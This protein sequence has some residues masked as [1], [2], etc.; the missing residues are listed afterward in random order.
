MDGTDKTTQQCAEER[1]SC[2]SD[3]SS[4]NC[5]SEHLPYEAGTC[6]AEG[7]ADGHLALPDGSARHENVCDVCTGEQ[8]NERAEDQEQ[9]R[10]HNERIVGV[11]NWAREPLVHHADADPF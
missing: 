2:S 10:K 8:Q 4:E 7:R 3:Q 6:A 5:L 11:R 9:S 1:P